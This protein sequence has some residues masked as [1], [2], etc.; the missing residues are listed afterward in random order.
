MNGARR[1]HPGKGIAMKR[2]ILLAVSAALALI[3]WWAALTVAQQT[4]EPGELF[5]DM[6]DKARWGEAEAQYMVGMMYAEGDGV[7]RN[8]EEAVRWFQEAADQG[9]AYGAQMQRRRLQS[10]NKASRTRGRYSYRG[11][12]RHRRRRYR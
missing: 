3:V 9:H 12:V 1:T 7:G 5:W 4:E 6:L 2:R 8:E 11:S 10:V